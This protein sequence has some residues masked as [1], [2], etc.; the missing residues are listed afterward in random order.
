MTQVQVPTVER[1]RQMLHRSD[2]L[3]VRGCNGHKRSHLMMQRGYPVFA[4][5]ARGCRFIDVDGNEY[6]DYLMGYGPILLGY[7]DP[8]VI[9]A[10]TRQLAHGTIN[11]LAHELEI[12]VG[13]L[14]LSLNPWA[15]KVGLLIGGSAA[16][17]AAVRAARAHTGRDYIIRCGYHGWHDWCVPDSA[18][19]PGPVGQLTLNFPYNDLEALDKA[20]ASRKGNVAGVIIETIQEDG[21]AD[22]FLRGC[23]DI[24]HKHGGL[25]IFDETKTGFRV[26]FGGAAE[27][28][29]LEPDI[30]TF[31]K[32]CANGFPA[33]YIVGSEKVLGSEP[34]QS[35][36]LAA[37]FHSDLLSL[38]AIPV[39]VSEMRRR[40]GFDHINRLGRRLIDGINR[41]CEA[42]GIPY[43]LGGL[44][45]MPTPLTREEDKPRFVPMLL[46]ALHRGFYLHPG[47]AMFISL[48]HTERDIEDTISAVEQSIADPRT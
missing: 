12:Q 36:W 48:A 31:G 45:A 17:E 15:G 44:P 20:F 16:T 41:A 6:V 25:C 27:H 28:Y 11:S 38:A 5:A 26:A 9:E 23:I 34:C 10:V 35:A 30:A 40:N 3:L 22:G 42:G 19:V 29:N 43:K 24:A 47:H 46:G 1:S 8:V 33:S 37:T 13:E 7:D 2:E 14:L 4:K 18:G 32:A 39:V 21:P